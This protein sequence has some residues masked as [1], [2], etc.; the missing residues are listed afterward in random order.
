MATLLIGYYH[1][2]LLNTINADLL[3][4]K[5]CSIGLLTA[6]EKSIIFSGHTVHC[7]NW[8]LLEHVRHLELQLLLE[9]CK[10]VKEESIET[11]S[12]LITGMETSMYVI[13]S[14]CMNNA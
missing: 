7:R 4:D 6:D 13:W 1:E 9:F 14:F 10:L 8:L 5:M 2:L 3:T 11:G 12:L